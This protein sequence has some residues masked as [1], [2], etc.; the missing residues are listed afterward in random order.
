MSSSNHRTE[1]GNPSFDYSMPGNNIIGSASQQVHTSTRIF[2]PISRLSPPLGSGG[3]SISDLLAASSSQLGS[4]KHNQSQQNMYQANGVD[5][6]NVV[7]KRRDSNEFN[8]DHERNT[9]VSVSTSGGPPKDYVPKRGYRACVHCRLRKA[10]CDLGDVNSPSEPPCT[11]C[12]REQRNCVFL[13]SVSEIL[14][15]LSSYETMGPNPI[16]RFAEAASEKS[17]GR[18]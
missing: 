14:K 3:A 10:R 8:D 11:R 12:R 5:Q 16:S 13:P 2:Q 4:Q 15:L 18:V 1:H 17:T 9:S 6:R 7:V